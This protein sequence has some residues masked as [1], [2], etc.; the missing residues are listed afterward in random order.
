MIQIQLLFRADVYVFMY[1]NGSG[2]SITYSI[3]HAQLSSLGTGSQPFGT[4]HRCLGGARIFFIAGFFASN[5]AAVERVKAFRLGL[6]EALAELAK[7]QTVR[8]MSRFLQAR[9][10]TRDSLLEWG[11]P[12]RSSSPRGSRLERYKYVIL[13]ALPLAMKK[14][15]SI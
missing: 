13:K 1:V 2:S 5:P 9:K 4:F 12:K 3:S 8:T 6:A 14:P 15:M 7:L 11:S 10:A